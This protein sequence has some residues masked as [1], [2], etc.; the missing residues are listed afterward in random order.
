M[1]HAKLI[2]DVVEKTEKQ[3]EPQSKAVQVAEEDV[4]IKE[5]AWQKAKGR[6]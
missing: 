4:V 5:Q 2:A 1:D 6:S 3:L